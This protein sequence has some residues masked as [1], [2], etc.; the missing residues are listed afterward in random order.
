MFTFQAENME[1]VQNLYS[2]SAKK[3]LQESM[4]ISE[5]N[6]RISIMDR[7]LKNK[8]FLEGLDDDYKKWLKNLKNSCKEK[9]LGDNSRKEE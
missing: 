6:P 5:K 3:S 9:F 4:A 7:N 8:K 2:K 1:L